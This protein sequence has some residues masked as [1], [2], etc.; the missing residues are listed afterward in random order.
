ME[1]KYRFNKFAKMLSVNNNQVLEKIKQSVHKSNPKA[2]AYLFGSRARGDNRTD[3]DWDILIL[4]DADKVTNEIEDK[5]RDGLYDLELDSGQIISTFIYP[6]DYWNKVLR[7]SP[8]Y[9]SV[10]LEGVRL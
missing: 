7:F 1:N 5:F 8:L 3:S 2:E 10:T 4:V 9:Q 6:K